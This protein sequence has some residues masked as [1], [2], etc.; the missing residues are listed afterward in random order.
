MQEFGIFFSN[1]LILKYII[2]FLIADV[3][4][5][6]ENL[7]KRANDLLNYLEDIKPGNKIVY[8]IDLFLQMMPNGIL[9]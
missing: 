6:S 1:M 7:L 9:K 2:I 8:N 4:Y 3:F 5:M